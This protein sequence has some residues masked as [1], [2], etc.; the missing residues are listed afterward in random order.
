MGF[1]GFGFKVG[2]V[3]SDWGC[4]GVWNGMSGVRGLGLGGGLGVWDL[5][6]GVW[7]R[8]P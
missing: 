6:F 8:W 5:E 7:T 4:K 3:G 1:W 2:G